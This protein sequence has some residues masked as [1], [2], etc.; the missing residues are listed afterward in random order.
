MKRAFA[1][2]AAAL[3][4]AVL[5][6]AAQQPPGQGGRGGG[7][8]AAFPKRPAADA[9]ALE[10]G[11]A[12]YSVNCQFCH[13]ADTRGGDAGPS[14]LRSQLVQDD[15]SG[16][17]VVTVLA[18][19]RPPAMPRFDFSREQASDIAAFLHSFDI[20]SRDPA[21]MRPETIV[22]GD[23]A[24]GE[25]YFRK[26]CASCHSLAGDLSG[27]NARFPDPRALQQWWL[28]PGGDG[29]GRG[30]QATAAA[31][32][33]PATATVTLPDGQ[34][35]EGRLVRLDEFAVSIMEAD[36]TTRSFRREREVPLVDIH[37]PLQQHRALLRAYSDKDIHDVTAY[38]V[39]VK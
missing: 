22:T 5:S 21:R 26:T 10:R 28:L 20:N 15:R 17:L 39:S 9:A 37:D 29:R 11:R 4:A 19:G 13:G 16:E 38:L 35:Y 25:A 33:K 23:A 31:R 14:L 1:G 36:G 27:L 3:A 18:A 32:L 2:T 6:V 7:A 8:A 12:L 30:A 34:K 24:A